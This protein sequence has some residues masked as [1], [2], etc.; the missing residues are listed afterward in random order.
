[1]PISAEELATA[2]QAYSEMRTCD[3]FR[4]LSILVSCFYLFFILLFGIF[5]AC[6]MGV[7]NSQ[8]KYVEG[9]E[10]FLSFLSFFWH[11]WFILAIWIG[12]G[13]TFIRLQPRYAGNLKVVTE[14][15][16]KYAGDLPYGLEQ[17]TL[18]Q[19]PKKALLW[20]LDAFLSRKP[21]DN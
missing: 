14:L 16:N 17:E 4:T 7:I 13:I 15:E 21:T 3:Y 20:R 2:K 12:Q 6:G 9:W 19:P 8:G 1:M 11:L 10:A 18:R 5:V